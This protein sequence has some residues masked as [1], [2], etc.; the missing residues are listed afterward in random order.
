[1]NFVSRIRPSYNTI[2]R[3]HPA[4]EPAPSAP[5]RAPPAGRAGGDAVVDISPRQ[6]YGSSAMP[7]SSS[8]TWAATSARV[9][10]AAQPSAAADT[11][12]AHKTAPK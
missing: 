6:Q 5:R 10:P 12:A 11:T 4:A 7:S 2:V 1:M 9:T 3:V 8:S